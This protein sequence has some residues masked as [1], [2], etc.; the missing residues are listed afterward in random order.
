MRRAHYRRY[1]GPDFDAS[2]AWSSDVIANIVGELGNVKTAATT[3]FLTR[4]GWRLPEDFGNGRFSPVD[5][6]A[7][8]F[9]LFF[10]VGADISV[11]GRNIFL[12]GNTF[13]DSHDVDKKS[14]VV[15]VPFG[16]GYQYGRFKT[17]LSMIWNS[18]EFK[19]Q[20]GA[21]LYG[22]WSIVIDY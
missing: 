11:I 21:D 16:V 7:D 10:F 8:G 19:G 3:G 5:A 12:D 1:R 14:F 20:D 2:G 6:T 4:F 9:R 13:R 22:R 18:K 15:H 17:K